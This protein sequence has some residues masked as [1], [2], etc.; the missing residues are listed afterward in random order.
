MAIGPG[1]YDA[2]A[3]H[4]REVTKAKGVLLIVIGGEHG[5]GFSAQLPMEHTLMIPDIL[6]RVADS[7][8]RDGPAATGQ[9]SA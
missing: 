7:I 4:V 6:R 5:D 8:E 3:T 1:R 9:G 2:L